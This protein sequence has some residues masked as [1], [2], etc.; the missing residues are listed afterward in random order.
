MVASRS[1]T[2]SRSLTTSGSILF[3][4]SF[5]FCRTLV[6]SILINEIHNLIHL[7]LF[8]KE[9]SNRFIQ[10]RKRNNRIDHDF[11][12]TTRTTLILFLNG[13]ED[14]TS[15]TNHLATTRHDYSIF[16]HMLI[17]KAIE[18]ARSRHLKTISEDRNSI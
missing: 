7:L 9:G 13:F 10:R 3:S 16:N 15:T 4:W 11:L 1:M 2:T 12:I 18:N 17:F 8:R 5:W 6:Q 14:M